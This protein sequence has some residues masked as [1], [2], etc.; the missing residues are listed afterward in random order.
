MDPLILVEEKV[1]A[2][3][4]ELEPDFDREEAEEGEIDC[5]PR[6][7]ILHT[8]IQKPQKSSWIPSGIFQWIFSGIVQRIF[9]FQWHVQRIVT[10]PVDSTGIVKWM[11]DGIFQWIVTFVI[12]G[13]ICPDHQAGW[14]SVFS[15]KAVQSALVLNQV[16]TA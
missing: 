11:L 4:E 14:L 1:P 12:S 7:R 16:K 9:T 2:V 5:P 3:R 10:G 8:R 6:G 15:Q 13:V